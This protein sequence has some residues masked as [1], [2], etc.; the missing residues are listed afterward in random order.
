MNYWFSADLHLNHNNIRKHCNRPFTSVEEMNLEIIKRWNEKVQPDDTG[1][2]LGDFC[3]KTDALQYVT[4]MNGR[5]ILIRGNHD[6]DIDRLHFDAVHDLLKVKIGG[7]KIVLCHYA[8]RVWDCSHHGSWHLYGHSHGS[9]EGEP[10]GLSMDVGV[11]THDFYPWSLADI[12]KVMEN[13]NV[14]AK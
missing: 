8:M 9:L 10:W 1:Y 14:Q 3:W 12:S 5:I 4:Q 2:I 7:Q 6:R 13:R 11:D